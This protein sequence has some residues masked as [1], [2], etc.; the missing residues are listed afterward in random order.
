MTDDISHTGYLELT[1]LWDHPV[2][3]NADQ[4]AAISVHNETTRIDFPGAGVDNF[5]RVREPF[6]EVRQQLAQL[7]EITM[8]AEQTQT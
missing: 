1:D 3:V 2:L 5:V 4:I 8:L 7:R 6:D